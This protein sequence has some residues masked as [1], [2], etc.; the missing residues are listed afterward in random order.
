MNQY[1]TVTN[2]AAFGLPETFRVLYGSPTL[3]NKSDGSY[4]NPAI[5]CRTAN[6]KSVHIR[7]CTSIKSGS[8]LIAVRWVSAKHWLKDDAEWLCH[9]CLF[10]ARFELA[11]HL[12]DLYINEVEQK[13]LI[14]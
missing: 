2:G 7:C 8:T 4:L 3:E 14:E 5:G 13:G 11:F 6:G 1:V 10:Q 12:L 9:H